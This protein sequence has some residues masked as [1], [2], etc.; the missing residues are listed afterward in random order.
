IGHARRR[1]RS[2][3]VVVQV[4][5]ALVLLVGAALMVEGFNANLS[6]EKQFQAARTLTAQMRLPQL[7]VY[8][9]ASARLAFFQRALDRLAA[10]PGVQGAAMVSYLPLGGNYSED[11]FSIE[12]Q[13]VQNASQRRY[14]VAQIITPNFFS[15]LHI[16]L[17]SGRAFTAADGTGAPAVVVISQGLAQRW[18][19]GKNPIGQV[20]KDGDDDSTSSWMTIVGVVSDVKMDFYSQTTPPAFYLPAAQSS[21]HGAFFLLRGSGSGDVTALAPAARQAVMAVDATI[22]LS[23][24]MSLAKSIHNATIGIAYVS[25]MLT[26]AGLLALILA[27]IGVYGVMAY[28]VGERIHEFGIRRALGASSG[29]L[30]GLVLRRGLVMLAWGLAIGLPVALFLA[31]GIQSLI[32]GISAS[33]I[34]TYL[35]V[36]VV[37]AAMVALACYIPARAAT[38]VDPLTALREP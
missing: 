35:G 26:V 31:R 24:V 8:D 22:P 4:A 1:L 15:L 34:P 21:P 37:L 11:S 28:L 2:A 19:A 23:A 38:R 20:I 30:I 36:S 6:G 9:A 32:V 5:L 3:L 29:A 13:P 12:G 7:P 33:D 14:A 16:P 27:A 18:F 25:V 17:L 10:L